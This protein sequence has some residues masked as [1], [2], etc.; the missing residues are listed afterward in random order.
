MCTA[1]P[2]NNRSHRE[3]LEIYQGTFCSCLSTPLIHIDMVFVCAVIIIHY[4]NG[5]HPFFGDMLR[6]VR[7]LPPLL[8]L[9]SLGHISALPLNTPSWSLSTEWWAYMIFPLWYRSSHISRTVGKILTSLFIIGFFVFIKYFLGT[10]VGPGPPTLNVI[11]DFG[12]FRCLAGFLAGMLLFRIYEE[13]IA[14]RF[15]KQSW[16]FVVLFVGRV[17]RWL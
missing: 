8:L 11:T 3:L 4:A 2:L 12:I 9:Q 7:C 10:H 16:V 15:F 17:L 6:P 14:Y 13:C 1:S 5:I